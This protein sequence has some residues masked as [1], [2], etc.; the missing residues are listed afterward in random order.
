MFKGKTF[1]IGVAGGIAAYKTVEIVSSLKK[2]EADIWVV[3]TE[4]AKKFVSP[5]TFRTI[6]KNPVV[7]TLF[8]E[9]EFMSKVPHI[10]LSKKA[11]LVLIA[12]ATANIIGKTAQGI[13]DDALSTIVMSA[14]CPKVIAPAMNS[15]MWENPI[16]QEN[17]SKLK[18]I[19]FSFWRPKKGFLVWGGGGK[20]KIFKPKKKVEKVF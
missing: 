10:A 5:L 8:D 3:M 13:A 9:A 12:P 20:G 2:L 11:D 19:G 4:S 18:G 16:V 6:S 7:T 17:C 1:I 14:L 15:R